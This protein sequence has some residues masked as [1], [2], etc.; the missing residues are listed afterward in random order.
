M[1]LKTLL[2]PSGASMSEAV[3]VLGFSGKSRVTSETLAPERARKEEA[4]DM[5]AWRRRVDE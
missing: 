1:P 4:E 3:L 2:T 5:K